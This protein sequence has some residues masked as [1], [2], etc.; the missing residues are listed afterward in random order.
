MV[1]SEGYCYSPKYLI[2]SYSLL[3]IDLESGSRIPEGSEPLRNPSLKKKFVFPLYFFSEGSS[4]YS[5]ER[6][7]EPILPEFIV[8]E[9]SLLYTNLLFRTYSYLLTFI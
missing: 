4:C 3:S 8:M 6:W 9:T 1:K 5:Q 7:N 2:Y